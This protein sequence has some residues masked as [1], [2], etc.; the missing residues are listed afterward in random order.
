MQCRLCQEEKELRRSHILPAF[1]RDDSALMY[2]TGKS[3]RPQPFTQPIHTHPGKRFQRKQHG[4]WEARH[5]MIQPLLCGDCERNLSGLEN[6]A[7]RSFYGSS[8][9]IRLQLPL[10]KDPLFLGNYKILKLFQL[11]ILWRAAEANGEFFSAV[12]LSHHHRERLREML[13]NDDPGTEDEYFC[14]MFRL[15][16][17]P[18][19]EQLQA[20]HGISIETGLF[21]P[22]A[23]NH[24]T[25]DLYAFLMGGLAWSFC[26]S[27][28][29]VPDI[30][31]NSYIKENGQFWL[32]PIQADGF[33]INFCQKAIA[34]GNVT[35]TDAEESIKAKLLV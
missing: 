22:I 10:L 12:N 35:R 9:P 5:G 31:R 23:H 18:L 26:V 28:R 30:M 32:M 7:K 17:S 15:V 25:W 27:Q 19:V 14:S 33:L 1:F 20:L 16:P 13:L 21:A 3:R 24:E 29:G 34:S 2:P 8:N 11:S 4:Y 6:Y